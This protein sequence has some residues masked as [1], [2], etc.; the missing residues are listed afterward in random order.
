MEDDIYSWSYPWG[1][2]REIKIEYKNDLFMWELD[3]VEDDE[4]SSKAEDLRRAMIYD[5]Q[6]QSANQIVEDPWRDDIPDDILEDIEEFIDELDEEDIDASDEAIVKVKYNKWVEGAERIWKGNEDGSAR[7]YYIHDG[8]LI[9]LDYDDSTTPLTRKKKAYKIKEVLANPEGF[10]EEVIDF[11]KH[12]DDPRDLDIEPIDDLEDFEE[13]EVGDIDE[14][15]ESDP[16]IQAEM[17]ADEIVDFEEVEE[18]Q[19][20]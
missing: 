20:E 12:I 3:I 9:R 17:K 4:A 13:V 1:D 16:D 19:A 11:L 15:L 2:D 7:E 10:P 18:D 5:Y 14:S 6:Y 8:V